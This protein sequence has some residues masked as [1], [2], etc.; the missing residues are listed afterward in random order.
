MKWVTGL[1]SFWFMVSSVQAA[2]PNSLIASWS[3]DSVSGKTF[4]DVTGHGYDAV[5]TGD[6]VRLTE[7]VSGKALECSADAFD[8]SIKN[9][10]G[11]FD[12]HRFTIEG[13]FYSAVDLVNPGTYYN[14]K[15]VFSYQR[16]GLGGSGI[17]GGFTVQITDQGK[18][19]FGIGDPV[20]N[21]WAS[22]VDDSTI[23]PNRWYYFA[24]TDDS[25][26]MKLFINGRLAAQMP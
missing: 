17:V 21:A 22:I 1:V 16:V 26:T 13:W 9:S 2:A 15:T 23:L 3:F 11:N 20:D 19:I 7:G 24:A 6:S 18:A 10:V 25:A 4:Y 14:W 5:A 8:I 12:L